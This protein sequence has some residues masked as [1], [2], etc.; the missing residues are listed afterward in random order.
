MALRFLTVFSLTMLLAGCGAW[1]DGGRADRADTCRDAIAASGIPVKVCQE[2]GAL[3]VH[4]PSDAALDPAQIAAIAQSSVDVSA[5][6]VAAQANPV[7]RKSTVSGCEVSEGGGSTTIQ[8]AL[9]ITLAQA[10]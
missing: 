2:G 7:V 10:D 9:T 8:C 4:A 3:T 1:R 5:I 6:P